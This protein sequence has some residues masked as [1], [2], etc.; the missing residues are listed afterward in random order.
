MPD[1]SKCR[2]EECPLKTKC[3]RYTSI[4]NEYWQSYFTEIPYD[5]E[6]NECD[7]YWDNIN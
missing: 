2:V 5:K 3:Y 7:H 6:A 4:A 1:I